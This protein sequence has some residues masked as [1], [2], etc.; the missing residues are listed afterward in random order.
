MRRIIGVLARDCRV[1][2]KDAEQALARQLRSQGLSLDEI[3]ARVGASKSSVSKWVRDI[4]L[5]AEQADALVSKQRANAANIVGWSRCARASRWEAFHRQ[6]EQQ[7]EELCKD[8][9]FMFGLA[10]YIG[11]GAKSDSNTANITNCDPRVIRKA[12]QF[13]ERIGA[14]HDKIKCQVFIHG[15]CEEAVVRKFW[16]EQTGLTVSAHLIRSVSRS[17]KGKKPRVQPHGTC[18]VF[19]CSTYLRQKIEQWMQMSLR[20]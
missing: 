8:P 13:F 10:L 20:G 18:R 3:A 16:T 6:A 11:E 9:N 19:V 17:S 7:Y 5:T 1:V 4:S 15:D 12:I 2:S 14:A